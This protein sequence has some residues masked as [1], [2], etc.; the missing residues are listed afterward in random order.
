MDDSLRSDL[1]TIDLRPPAD[2]ATRHLAGSASFPLPTLS[3]RSLELPPASAGPLRLV[4]ADEPSAAEAVAFLAP[5][6]GRG[7]TIAETLL[8]TDELWATAARVGLLEHGET[9]ATL[10]SPSPHLPRLAAL[11]EASLSASALPVRAVDLGCGRGRDVVWLAQ[12]GWRVVGVDNRRPLLDDLHSFAARTGVGDRVRGE[13][14]DVHKRRELLAALLDGV[15][16]VNLARFM[17]RSLVDE[18]VAAMPAGSFLA[19]HHFL[20]G[21]VSLKAMHR[22]I[23]NGDADK[24]NLAPG[25]LRARY[26]AAGEVLVDDEGETADGRP[27][28][29]FVLRRGPAPF[30]PRATAVGYASLLS[31]S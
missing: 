16:V 22:E 28:C 29:S 8:A 26:A 1:P 20:E 18:V 6:A 10:W 19:V 15:Q 3:T 7:W 25:E 5:T 17:S 21:A 13:L 24:G 31:D 4:A 27:I 11:V 2:Y 14:L 9:S 30:F 12:R 23:K